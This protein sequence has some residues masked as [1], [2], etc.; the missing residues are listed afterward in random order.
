MTR[1][2]VHLAQR[3]ERVR[4]AMAEQGVDALLL[5]LGAD[6]PWLTGYTAM[7]LER[8]TM[9]VLPADGD[10]TLVVPGLEAPRVEEHPDVFSIVPWSDTEDPV[11]IVAKLVGGRR[12][13]AI[14]ARAWHTFVLHA[15]PLL[16]DAA[17]R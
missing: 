11:A 15:Q 3:V 7:P 10:A 16:P 5:S 14:S 13:L 6:L 1:T 2:S 8:L 17:W 12:P 9:L 4:S